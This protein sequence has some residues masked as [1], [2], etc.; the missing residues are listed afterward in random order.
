MVELVS[1]QDNFP[2]ITIK[3]QVEEDV[4]EWDL[5]VSYEQD[6]FLKSCIHYE[7]E[8]EKKWAVCDYLKVAPVALQCV[9]AWRGVTRN[10]AEIAFD[11]TLFPAI[12][13]G[14][15]RDFLFAFKAYAVTGEF[16]NPMVVPATGPTENS[17]NG[18]ENP[19]TAGG[20]STNA[21]DG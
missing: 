6:L 1:I 10:G 3:T 21:V 9:T 5:Q 12:P 18:N 19:E 20:S 2:Q 4:I 14:H 15:R 11:P 16:P 8:G 7:L 17:K 13:D